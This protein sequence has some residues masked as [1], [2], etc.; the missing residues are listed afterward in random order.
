[1]TAFTP[2]YQ[3]IDGNGNP[4]AAARMYFFLTGTLTPKTTYSDAGLTTPNTHP[5]VADANGRF[6]P[7]YLATDANYKVI[8]NDSSDTPVPGG[9]FDPLQTIDPGLVDIHGLTALTAP[10]TDD[11]LPIYDASASTNKRITLENVLK[12]VAS[13]TNKATPVPAD[14][15]LLND[16][17]SSNAAKY[18]LVSAVLAA[19]NGLTEDTSADQQADFLLSYDTSATA[20]KKVLMKKLPGVAVAHCSFNGTGTPATRGTPLNVASITDNGTG[21]WT[22]NYTT[23]LATANYSYTTGVQL[24]SG[25]NQTVLSGTPVATPTTSALRLICSS[26]S[27]GSSTI[28][29]SDSVFVNLACHSVGG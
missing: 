14:I 17:A 1:M 18:A 26:M 13:L 21:D 29:A 3:A 22:V 11:E 12:V 6:G 4:Y 28:A 23:A 24:V 20:A 5:V 8:L 15:M 27:S 10:A 19:L 9:T 16:S 2:Y 7:I 25:S